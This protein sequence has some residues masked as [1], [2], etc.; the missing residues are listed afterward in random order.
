MSVCGGMRVCVRPTS[1]QS[2]HNTGKRQEV[3]GSMD[4]CVCVHKQH[5]CICYVQFGIDYTTGTETCKHAVCVWVLWQVRLTVCAIVLTCVCSPH[6]CEHT[7]VGPCMLKI[8]K[9]VYCHFWVCVCV[10]VCICVCVCVHTI[11]NTHISPIFSEGVGPCMVRQSLPIILLMYNAGSK[12]L[13]LLV[14][15]CVVFMWNTPSL[16]SSD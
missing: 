15:V 2:V 8:H 14:C 4:V 13:S 6:A 12:Y 10:F 11:Y 16:S 5:H 3:A 7:L 9:P 1:H